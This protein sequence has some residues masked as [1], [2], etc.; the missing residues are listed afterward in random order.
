MGLRVL[1]LE[2]FVVLASEGNFRRTKR[3][4]R[5]SLKSQIW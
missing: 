5:V 4:V 1:R 3:V 2:G